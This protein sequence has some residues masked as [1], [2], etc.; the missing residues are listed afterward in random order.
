MVSDVA[1]K[2]DFN[3][4]VDDAVLVLFALV[5]ESIGWATAALL[6]QDVERAQQVIEDDRGID[7]RCEEL[8]GLVKE[9]L[10]AGVLPPDELENLIAV[11]QIVPE[12][13]RS[14]DLAEHIA[15][16]AARSIGGVITA[17]SRGLIQSMSDVAVRMWQVAGTAYRQ[18]SREA[19]FALGEADDELDDLASNL[20]LD[21]AAEGAHPAVAAE[22]A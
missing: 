22:L 17:R 6:E 8:A 13:E 4:R 18:R 9:R 2:D 5:A 3:R 10:S 11:L 20:V 12:L 7:E 14:A 21:G 16:R 15:Q 19:S 1:E